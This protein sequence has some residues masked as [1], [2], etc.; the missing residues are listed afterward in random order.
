MVTSWLYIAALTKQGG[1]L[2]NINLFLNFFSKKSISELSNIPQTSK[3]Y[4]QI[5]QRLLY[6]IREY[7]DHRTVFSNFFHRSKEIEN[8]NAPFWA[9]L[10]S[11]SEID[12][13]PK[14]IEKNRFFQNESIF[15]SDNDKWKDATW[16]GCFAPKRVRTPLLRWGRKIDFLLETMQSPWLLHKKRWW[17]SILEVKNWFFILSVKIAL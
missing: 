2:M 9:P 12:E 15:D 14:K 10:R 7:G 5:A 6:K 8:R 13:D 4:S 16:Q 17:S 3:M 1:V 11:P